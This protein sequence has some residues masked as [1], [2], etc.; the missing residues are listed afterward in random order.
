MGQRLNVLLDVGLAFQLAT[1]GFQRLAQ[2]ADLIAARL[3][4]RHRFTG[5]DRL[6]IAVETVHAVHQPRGHQQADQ[7]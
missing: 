3:R 7:R 1:H 2:I 5:A 6:G 4:R